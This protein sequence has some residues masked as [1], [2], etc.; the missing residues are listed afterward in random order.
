MIL[1]LG[2]KNSPLSGNIKH[3]TYDVIL[4]GPIHSNDS[5]ILVLASTMVWLWQKKYTIHSL[6]TDTVNL[7]YIHQNPSAVRAATTTKGW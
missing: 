6:I 4:L 5:C 3:W 1:K 2:R 7:L